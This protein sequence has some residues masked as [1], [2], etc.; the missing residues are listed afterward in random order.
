MAKATDQS[1]AGS[2]TV[3]TVA[4]RD[5]ARQIANKLE[6]VGIASV[7]TA[8]QD[9]DTQ[10]RRHRFS[11]I[12]VQVSRADAMR[13]VQLLREKDG[14]ASAPS[15]DAASVPQRSINLLGRADWRHGALGIV[16]IIGLAAFLAAWLF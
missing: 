11:E 3:A 6:A 13:A 12:K 1:K 4:A 7:L 8:E 10:N 2:V 9:L 5:E 14:G 15:G 16:A